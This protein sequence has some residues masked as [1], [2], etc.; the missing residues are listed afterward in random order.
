[1]P[2]KQPSKFSFPVAITAIIIVFLL[3]YFVSLRPETDLEIVPAGVQPD[4]STV[5]NFSLEEYMGVWYELGRTPVRFEEG[6]ECVTAEYELQDDSVKVLNTCKREGLRD[7][8]IQGVATTTDTPGILSV[9][10]FP[11]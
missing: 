1:M 9:Q 10:F 6:C 3:F 4:K 8:V 5:Q 2:K 11:L 7:E